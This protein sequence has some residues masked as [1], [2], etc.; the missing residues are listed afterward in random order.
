MR[1]RRL[2]PIL[3]PDELAELFPAAPGVKCPKCGKRP[4]WFGTD[5]EHPRRRIHA[6]NRCGIR[7]GDRCPACGKAD[8][9]LARTFRRSL[10]YRCPAC[11]FAKTRPLGWVQNPPRYDETLNAWFALKLSKR[12]RAIEALS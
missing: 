11:G 8:L 3:T 12:Q 10:R 5:P 6:C 9:Q 7:F 2:N 1:N 4:H